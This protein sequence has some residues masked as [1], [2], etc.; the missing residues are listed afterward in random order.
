MISAEALQYWFLQTVAMLLTAFVIP[1]FRIKGPLAALM[2]VLVL[3][4]VN[5]T[6]WDAALFLHIP[7]SATTHAA[8][9]LLANG[10][11]FWI[12]VKLIPGI[13]VIGL[14]PA[15]AAPVVFSLVSVLTYQYGREID[16]FALGEQAIQVI[17]R[18]R[19][20]LSGV[21]TAQPGGG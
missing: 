17:T 7:D 2:L 20:Q 10:I 15:L 3:G 6:I 21:K 8:V 13:E 9:V 5:S 18:I 4:F 19:D 11:L 12:L 1:R 16:W 14:L